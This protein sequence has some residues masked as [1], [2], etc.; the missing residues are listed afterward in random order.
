MLLEDEL[1][2]PGKVK[3]VGENKGIHGAQML[4]CGNWAGVKIRCSKNFNVTTRRECIE[5]LGPGFFRALM[6][7]HDSWDNLG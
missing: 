3:R 6:T 1:I 7:A 4:T 2:G 5:S